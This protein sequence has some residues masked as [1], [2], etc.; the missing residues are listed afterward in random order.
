MINRSLGGGARFPATHALLATHSGG[1]V[2]F[3]VELLSK[4]VVLSTLIGAISPR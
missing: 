2:I 3:V 4:R 1:I